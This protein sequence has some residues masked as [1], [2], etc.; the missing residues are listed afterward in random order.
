MEELLVNYHWPGNVRELK[1]VIERAIILESK[2]TILAE[3]LPAE[4]RSGQISG[5]D[6]SDFELK[7]PP[8]GISLDRLEENLLKQALS[9][10]G[11]NQTRAAKLLGLGRDALRYRMK[12]TGLLK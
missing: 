10:S 5:E 8:T 1:N 12:K 9:L 6:S 3:H 7:I 4:I 2:E 11:H